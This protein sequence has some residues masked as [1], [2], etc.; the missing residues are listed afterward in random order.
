M[1][2][3]PA[4]HIIR[5]AFRCSAELQELLRLLKESGSADDYEKYRLSIAAAIDAI[6]VQLTAKV[7]AAHPGL[8]KRIESELNQF[9]RLV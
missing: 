2:Q 7:L 4:W 3:D 8:E 1:T 6:N 9:G 5:T